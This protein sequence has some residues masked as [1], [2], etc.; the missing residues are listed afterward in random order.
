[1][2]TPWGEF[3]VADAHVHFFSR[4]FFSALAAQSG[5]TAEQVAEAAG[6]VLPPEDPVELARTWVAELDSHGV[7]RAALIASVPGDEASVESAVSAFPDRFYGYFMVNPLEE[8]ALERAQIALRCGLHAVCLFPA[9][10]PL[11]DTGPA[12]RG[13]SF[14][15]RRNTAG[16]PSSST[17]ACSRSASARSWDFPRPSTCAIPIRSTCTVWRCAIRS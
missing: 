4:N 11:F 3:A 9:D 2:Q 14:R 1:M 7:A 5:K 13:H 8:D 10:A 12:R 16:A 6:W 17:A 15:R